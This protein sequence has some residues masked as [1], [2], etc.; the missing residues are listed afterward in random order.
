MIREGTTLVDVRALRG[1]D[2]PPVTGPVAADELYV[3]AGAFAEQANAERLLARLRA[4]GIGVAFIRRDDA[5]G[6]PLFRVRVGPVPSV[7][8]FDRVVAELRGVGVH[9]ARL[10][11]E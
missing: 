6:R 4:A 5:N 8:E 2:D 9:D 11:T 7:A 10:A 3:Q 1:V